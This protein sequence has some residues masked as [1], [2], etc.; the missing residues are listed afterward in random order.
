MK[1][2]YR[3]LILDHD[4]TAV[5]STAII[6][7]PAHLAALEALR[8]GKS[9]PSLETWFLKNFEPGLMHYLQDELKMD[10]RELERE[11]RIWREFTSSL[12]PSFYDGFLELLARY[13]RAGGLVTV[14][15]HSESE[16][17]A[18]DY[19][20]GKPRVVPDMILGW[21]QDAGKRKPDPWP[22]RR[23][24]KQFGL[25][26]GQALIVDDLKPGVM[27]A[28]AAGVDIAAAGWGHSIP[29]IRD[30]MIANCCRY[31]SS[32]AELGAYLL[33]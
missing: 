10:S 6:H 20:S 30:Y 27:M 14:V 9:I 29:I 8:P 23:I 24:L 31:F 17:I 26:E 22:V 18:R 11:Y 28:R 16:F 32:I 3:C 19:H 15:S 2:R 1:L 13:Q 33:S 21:N 4:D 12:V 7:Y 5:N 25:E